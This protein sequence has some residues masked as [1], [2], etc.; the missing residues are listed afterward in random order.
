VRAPRPRGADV[1][2][3]NDKL[4][5]GNLLNAAGNAPFEVGKNAANELID[6]GD[7]YAADATLENLNNLFEKARSSPAAPGTTPWWSTTWTAASALAVP[8]SFRHRLAWPRDSG[9]CRQ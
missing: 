6:A 5:I 4:V 1:G 2:L 7:R 3:Y 8:R 9:Q